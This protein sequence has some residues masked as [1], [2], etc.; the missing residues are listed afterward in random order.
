MS[1][2]MDRHQQTREKS[3][4]Q[5]SR[6]MGLW[7]CLTMMIMMLGTATNAVAAEPEMRLYVSD[8]LVTEENAS[9]VLG[10]GAAYYDAK[11][12]VL[13]VKTSLSVSDKPLI[14]VRN[15]NGLTIC[16]SDNVTMVSSFGT[17]G[18]I[19]ILDSKNVTVRGKGLNF[20]Q[21]YSQKG[22]EWYMPS[23]FS[24][25]CSDVTFSE[26]SFTA[27]TECYHADRYYSTLDLTFSRV[28]F[29]GTDA[30]LI[31]E[32]MQNDGDGKAEPIQFVD[33]E[34]LV[35]SYQVK[36]E[37]KS[38]VVLRD[39]KPGEGC[40]LTDGRIFSYPKKKPKTL[41][42]VSQPRTVKVEFDLRGKD[43]VSNPPAT[44]SLKKGEK[45]EKPADPVLTGF[46]FE[47]W[48]TDIALTE[49]YDFEASVTKDL[50]L[51]AKWKADESK[52]EDN[53]PDKGGD[54][55]KAKDGGKADDPAKKEPDIIQ[56][57]ATGDSY[58]IVS[59]DA[60]SR[61]VS[62]VAPAPDQKAIVIPA[63]VSLGGVAYK[64][65]SIAKGAFKGNTKITSVVI[66][67]NVK[68]IEESAFEGCTA[69]QSVDC[70]STVLAKIGKKAFKGDKKLTKLILKTKKLKAKKVGKDAIKST[71]KKLVITAPSNKVKAYKT[72]FKAKGNKKVKVKKA[73]K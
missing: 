53:D 26:C 65:E 72:I 24:L 44:Q 49:E 38:R 63:S 30:T 69:L 60:K 21:K 23:L 34:S 57:P 2:R 41:T 61:A 15:G 73:K 48:Y 59:D 50:T 7:L 58:V 18:A 28:T 46:T 64:V 62:F 6:T 5:K 4:G 14:E 70:K 51:Y 68:A 56:D 22:L 39:T 11:E 42:F 27:K 52:P 10:N 12:N 29:E 40:S 66:G 43:G 36:V 9:D 33:N 55:G 20:I 19:V 47:G 32:A 16:F 71:S 54:Q 8:T 35:N 67:K 31:C 37:E 3:N 1:K 25:C 17:S 13:Y 45:A